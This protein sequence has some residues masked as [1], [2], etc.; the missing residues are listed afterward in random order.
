MPD[1]L[2]VRRKDV[3]AFLGISRH[4]FQNLVDAG[5]IRPKFLRHDKRGRPKGHPMYSRVDVLQLVESIGK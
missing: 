5:T 3:M 4:Q 2:L 1:C